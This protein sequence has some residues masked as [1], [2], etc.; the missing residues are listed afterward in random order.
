MDKVGWHGVLLFPGVRWVGGVPADSH[1]QT[2]KLCQHLH[3]HRTHACITILPACSMTVTLKT[4][5]DGARRASDDKLLFQLSSA[6]ICTTCLAP[7][8][9]R[10]K[11]TKGEATDYS[12]PSHIAPLHVCRKY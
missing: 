11:Y 3:V 12:S 7:T 2:L 5:H 10:C 6:G 9:F 1:V 8:R 4:I